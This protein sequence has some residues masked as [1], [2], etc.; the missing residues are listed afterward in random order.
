[1]SA[2][3][4]WSALTQLGNPFWVFSGLLAAHAASRAL[5]PVFMHLVPPADRTGSPPARARWLRTL[6]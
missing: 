6:P 4:R 2:L 1:M 3:I 5:L